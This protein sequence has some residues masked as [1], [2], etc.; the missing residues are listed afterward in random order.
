MDAFLTHWVLNPLVKLSANPK[1]YRL[2][3]AFERLIPLQAIMALGILAY[4]FGLISFNLEPALHL[5]PFL[6][7]LSISYDFNSKDAHPWW[8]ISGLSI[9]L[10]YT[11]NPSLRIDLSFFIVSILA[12]FGFEALFEGLDNLL[13]KLKIESLPQKALIANARWAFTLVLSLV[14]LS[15]SLDLSGFTEFLTIGFSLTNTLWFFIGVNSLNTWIWYKG[16][17]GT[18]VLSIWV[19]PISSLALLLNLYAYANGHVLPYRFAGYMYAIFGNYAIFS[20]I[21]IWLRLFPKSKAD[22]DLHA[23]S[24][25]S[26]WVNINESLIYSLPLVQNTT[27]LTMFLSLN[28]LNM[29]ILFK[30]FSLNWIQPF[31]FAS[32]FTLP[33]LVQA[34]LGMGAYQG[35]LVWLV[36]VFIDVLLMTPWMLKRP[37]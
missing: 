34:G 24:R 3:T 19:L 10:T 8:M 18:H 21:Q 33:S 15:L 28:A 29:I 26:T 37:Y 4:R 17:H 22:I 23:H 36:L 12:P 9:L 31:F 5:F 35:S 32:P 30:A 20:A 25:M 7:S 27:I 13:T 11:L 16:H 6:M 1:L 2:K 14:I